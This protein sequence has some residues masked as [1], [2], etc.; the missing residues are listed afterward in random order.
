M[1]INVE[2]AFKRVA[3]SHVYTKREVMEFMHTPGV[4]IHFCVAHP[5]VEWKE[6]ELSWDRTFSMP[7]I[8]APYLNHSVLS[9]SSL[10]FVLIFHEFDEEED[11]LYPW[12]MCM[13]TPGLDG[14]IY[15]DK[16]DTLQLGMFAVR[17]LAGRNS[18]D[19]KGRERKQGMDVGV[20]DGRCRGR[21]SKEMLWSAAVEAHAEA[22]DGFN[23]N[24][25]LLHSSKNKAGV[26]DCSIIPSNRP[27]AGARYFNDSRNTGKTTNLEIFMDGVIMVAERVT[28]EPITSSTCWVDLKNYELYV[29]YGNDYWAQRALLWRK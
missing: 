15:A 14:I 7:S 22:A 21:G 8:M 23:G 17:T 10:P 3:G 4:D 26:F 1:P 2:R 18:L 12:L 5:E 11:M 24:L 13:Q 9:A 16:M 25:I 28:M 29:N 27:Q 19:S 20:F 6:C